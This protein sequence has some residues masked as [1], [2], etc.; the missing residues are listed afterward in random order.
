MTAIRAGDQD[1]ERENFQASQEAPQ[2]KGTPL[3]RQCSLLFV[4][5]SSSAHCAASTRKSCSYPFTDC[6]AF[7]RC[8]AVI[9][10]CTRE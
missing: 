10:L 2:N 7:N 9:A 6:T 5:L 4:F 3:Q 8:P 1:A